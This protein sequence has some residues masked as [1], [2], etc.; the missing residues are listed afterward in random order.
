MGDVVMK[1]DSKPD[2]AKRQNCKLTLKARSEN[3]V[4][5]STKSL[6]HGLITKREIIPGIYLAESLTKVVNGKCISSIINIL[7][8][9]ITLDPPQVLLEQIDDSGEAMTLL[10]IAVLVV[11]GLLPRSR[12]QLRTDHLNDE[13]RVSLVKICEEYHDIFHLSG[14]K[15]IC[16][17]AAEHAIPTPTIDP[18]RAINT[19]ADALSRIHVAETMPTE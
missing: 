1:F 3:I 4:K 16:T 13:E 14:D 19:N 5:V 2:K 10:H 9:D 15:V 8:E 18:S 7:E 6:G 12:E 17:T 11:T